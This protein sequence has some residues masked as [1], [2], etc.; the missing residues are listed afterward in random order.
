M[1]PVETIKVITL[2]RASR[3]SLT[4][5]EWLERQRTW[6]VDRARTEGDEDALLAA[7]R[8]LTSEQARTL[9][10]WALQRYDARPESLDW[11][12]L[13]GRI[14]NFVDGGLLGI[15]SELLAR[16]LLWPGWIYRGADP[17]TRDHLIRRVEERA[18]HLKAL[19]EL[20][21]C[22]AWIGDETVQAHF[23]S[24][25]E[26]P[27]AW[28]TVLHVA[29]E[30]YS[31]EADWE[32][33]PAGER[34]DLFYAVSYELVPFEEA[35]GMGQPSPVHAPVPE[36]V[37]GG[38]CGWC[39]HDL[40]TL[41]DLDLRDPRLAFL[42][43]SGTKLRIA[44]CDFCSPYATVFTDV[45][46]EGNVRWS[47]S[48]GPQPVDFDSGWEEYSLVGRQLVLGPIRRTPAETVG[49][50]QGAHNSE[51]G[52]HP[53]WIQDAEYPVCPECQ[54]RM[55]FIGQVETD[56]VIRDAEGITYAFLCAECGK[57]ATTYQQT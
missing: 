15:Y 10:Q 49:A 19:N 1:D 18:P 7:F 40:S 39:E 42:G 46:F 11:Q 6:E 14:A 30:T 56:D 45:D 20:L 43:C 8:S 21:L 54:R 3:S 4:D 51:L 23:R 22:L 28:R 36:P 32:L 2:R 12:G 34:R 41:F 27:P 17:A 50:Y 31:Y 52:G 33:T 13:L 55:M 35:D 38:K 57:A 29:P 9:A 26:Q 37:A 47:A 5:E 48:N 24:W 53:D 16:D 25:R 44:R